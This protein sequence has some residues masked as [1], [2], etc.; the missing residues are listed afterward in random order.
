MFLIDIFYTQFVDPTHKIVINKSMYMLYV[1]TYVQ[2]VHHQNISMLRFWNDKI[3]KIKFG[4]DGGRGG[5][6]MNK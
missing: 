1:H 4:I 3:H 2:Y 5:D 6:G